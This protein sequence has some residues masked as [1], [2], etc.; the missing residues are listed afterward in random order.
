MSHY[1]TYF[2]PPSPPTLSLSIA[3]RERLEQGLHNYGWPV[4]HSSTGEETAKIAGK[5]AFS[6]KYATNPLVYISFQKFQNC[7]QVYFLEFTSRMTKELTL[8]GF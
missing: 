1:L 7:S 5:F 2:F 6:I 8:E 3:N 4:Q